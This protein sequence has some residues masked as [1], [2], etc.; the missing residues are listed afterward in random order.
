MIEWIESIIDLKQLSEQLTLLAAMIEW[1]YPLAWQGDIDRV[2]HILN[3]LR[4]E[5]DDKRN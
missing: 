5:K 1:E 4:G 2:I 3:E